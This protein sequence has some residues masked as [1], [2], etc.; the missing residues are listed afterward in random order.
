MK[1]RL[2]LLQ[3]RKKKNYTQKEVSE[4]C[5]ISRSY[6]AD[7]EQGTANASGRAAKL[8]AD[9]LGFEMSL[10]FVEVGRETRQKKK[11]PA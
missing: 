2:W 7:I 8:I 9:A 3:F 1:E 11:K 10:F 4:K 5:G 6:Y